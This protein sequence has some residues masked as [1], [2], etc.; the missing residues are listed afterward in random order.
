MLNPS[1]LSAAH[2]AAARNRVPILGLIAQYNGGKS[3]DTNKKT[4]SMNFHLDLNI[5]DK[6]GWTP[7]HHAVRNSALNAIEFLLDNG[8]ID[9]KLTKN[10]ETPVHFAIVHNQMKAL[11][12][13][14]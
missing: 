11:E 13:C 10:H 8:V 4:S 5:E 9:D 6:N 3:I 2:N 7:L 12:V 1:G 14:A